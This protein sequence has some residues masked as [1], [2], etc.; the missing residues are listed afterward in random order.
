V[1]D[2]YHLEYF[3]GVPRG[4]AS[5]LDGLERFRRTLAEERVPATFFTLGEIAARGA[6]PLRALVD[7]GHEIASH[8]PDHALL[9]GMPADAFARQLGEDRDR[10]EQAVSAP[11]LGYRAPCFSMD[12]EKLARLPELGFRYDSSWIRCGDHPLYGRMELD[13]W[14]EVADGVRRSPGGGFLE[15]EVPTLELAGRRVPVGGGAYFRIFPWPLT[16]A[17]VGR[18]LRRSG[19]YVFY[20]HP[21][22]CSAVAGVDYPPGTGAGTRLRFQA[23]RRRTLPRLRRLI[24]L[25]RS[26]GFEFST[27][28]AAAD[29]LSA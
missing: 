14:P 12:R 26:E 18:H 16:R 21:F 15:F 5:M 7:E 10:L 29:A 23:G 19:T 2:W 28:A 4:G 25:L 3:A 6:A 24:R 9:G 8:G 20:I 27:F 11:V 22:E 17:L 13:D 1:E